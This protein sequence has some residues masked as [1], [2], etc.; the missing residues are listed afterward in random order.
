MRSALR[1]SW[2]CWAACLVLSLLG[3]TDTCDADDTTVVPFADGR[4]NAAGTFYETSP[5][6][7]PYLHFP[8]GR[9]FELRHGLVSAPEVVHTYLS[10]DG[11]ALLAGASNV[12]ES[13]GNQAVIERVDGEV[14]RVRND[15]CSEFYLRVA[16]TVHAQ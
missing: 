6:Q 9:A 10:F 2:P 12:A 7:G 3:C 5:I 16:A 15:T 11:E 13:A 4:T 1:W 8:S 14:V